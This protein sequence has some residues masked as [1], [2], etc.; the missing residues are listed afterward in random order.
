MLKGVDDTAL[1]PQNATNRWHIGNLEALP[2]SRT[3][4]LRNDDEIGTDVFF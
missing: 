3:M 4:Y 1:V 2:A